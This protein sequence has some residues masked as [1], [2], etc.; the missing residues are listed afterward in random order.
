VNWVVPSAIESG[1]GTGMPQAFPQGGSNGQIPHSYSPQQFDTYSA[2]IHKTGSQTITPSA[3]SA[4][5]NPN[6]YN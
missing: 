2:P 1:Q 3:P 5:F 4:Q 6:S